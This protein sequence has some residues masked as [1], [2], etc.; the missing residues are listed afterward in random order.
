MVIIRHVYREDKNFSAKIRRKIWQ[1]ITT[2]YSFLRTL[3]GCV[4]NKARLERSVVE[5][6]IAIEYL[7]FCS[8][9]CGVETR[10]TQLKRNYDGSQEDVL[11]DIME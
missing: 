6:Y 4:C 7:A 11:Q 2:K 10:F 3:K 5:A 8:Y 9:L 1:N